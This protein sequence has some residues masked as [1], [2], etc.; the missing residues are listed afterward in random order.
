MVEQLDVGIACLV[1]PAHG[2]KGDWHELP[3]VVYANFE[4]CPLQDWASV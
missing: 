2:G 3:R 4:G 1:V